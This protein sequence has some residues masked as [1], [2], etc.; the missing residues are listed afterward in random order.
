MKKEAVDPLLTKRNVEWDEPGTPEVPIDKGKQ[1]AIPEVRYSPEPVLPKV[2]KP[3]KRAAEESMEK[4]QAPPKKKQRVRVFP[5]KKDLFQSGPDDFRLW[6]LDD[7]VRSRPG[8]LPKKNGYSTEI[9]YL[10]AFAL[11]SVLPAVSSALLSLATFTD[12]DIRRNS[13]MLRRNPSLYSQSQPRLYW[14]T[15]SLMVQR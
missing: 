1:R 2:E 8:E 7:H 10:V 11:D 9:I 14:T 3:V 5:S 15:V 6:A 4:S 13:S 12:L